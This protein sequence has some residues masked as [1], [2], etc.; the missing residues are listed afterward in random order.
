MSFPQNK[1]YII[2]VGCLAIL[3]ALLA[4]L[5]YGIYSAI[6]SGAKQI[7]SDKKEVVAMELQNN[8]IGDFK[9]RHQEYQPN[10]QRVAELF[11]DGE[12]P[13]SFITFLE[14]ISANA[15]TQVQIS[16]MT[17]VKSENQNTRPPIVFQI[18]VEGDYENIVKFTEKLENGPYLVKVANATVKKVERSASDKSEAQSA[19]QASFLI[20]AL[21]K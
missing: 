5:T 17:G 1:T 4:F 12:N 11:V 21:P 10:L 20:E 15:N 7:A 14:D 13:I 8:I 18:N 2:A 19:L 3:I 6:V 9:A 16:I